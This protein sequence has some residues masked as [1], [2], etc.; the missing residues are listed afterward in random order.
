MK[1]LTAQYALIGQAVLLESAQKWLRDNDSMEEVMDN[2]NQWISRRLSQLTSRHKDTNFHL[3]VHGKDVSN[4]KTFAANVDIG[5][6]VEAILHSVI[7]VDRLE[8]LERIV[9][10]EGFP[11]EFNKFQIASLFTDHRP[12]NVLRAN[13][14][15]AIVEFSNKF[16]AAQIVI[17]YDKKTFSDE[18]FVLYVSSPAFDPSEQLKQLSKKI[19]SLNAVKERAQEKDVEA[20]ENELV[21]SLKFDQKGSN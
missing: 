4:V 1:K 11:R 10:V 19:S 7:D 21:L 13:G 9:V 5:S 16:G 20:K 12:T 6:S 2:M 3:F 15:K 14:N 18:G 17:K 8:T